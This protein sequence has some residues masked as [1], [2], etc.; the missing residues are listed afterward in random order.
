MTHVVAFIKAFE[1]N[2]P[3]LHMTK[4]E[5]EELTRLFWECQK[6]ARA[7]LDKAQIVSPTMKS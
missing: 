6:E 4:E 2:C 7:A 1:R 3:N 5:R